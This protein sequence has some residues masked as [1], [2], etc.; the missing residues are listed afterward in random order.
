MFELFIGDIPGNAGLIYALVDELEVAQKRV[1]EV[2]GGIDTLPYDV[3]SWNGQAREAFDI[4]HADRKGETRN[5]AIDL[6][7]AAKN[8]AQYADTVSYL[9]ARVDTL[10][11]ELA[12]IEREIL[13]SGISDMWQAFT[14]QIAAISDIRQDYHHFVEEAKQAAITCASMLNNLNNWEP[15]HYHDRKDISSREPLDIDAVLEELDNPDVIDWTS[16]RQGAIGDCFFLSTIMA[17]M[18]TEGGKEALTNLI[19]PHYGPDN[20]VDGFLVTFYDN[21]LNPKDSDSTTVFVDSRYSHGVRGSAI[22]SVLESAY[23]RIH[24]GGTH[25]MF[26]GGIEGGI[27]PATYS[28]LTN[29]PAEMIFTG[30]PFIEDGQLTDAEK[31]RII[32]ASEDHPMVA[33]T[34]TSRFRLGGDN[35]IVFA[36]DPP[37]DI[38]LA[39]DHVYMIEGADENGVTLR[40]PWGY[41]NVEQHVSKYPDPKDSNPIAPAVFTMSWHDFESHFGSVT[42]GEQP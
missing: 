18:K 2:S 12:H 34:L 25:L 29:K 5:L 41:N 27:P 16:V 28:E 21:P 8:L 20:Q 33:E 38:R 19:K 11:Q 22:A 3:P 6:D 4:S 7:I 31:E 10:K 30:T 26:V 1:Q 24:S 39:R 13:T 32:T 37:C 17:L 15:P 42:I 35:A 23:G 9:Q 40:N 36:Q 14:H